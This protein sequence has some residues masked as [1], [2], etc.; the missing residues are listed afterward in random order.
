MTATNNS[1]QQQNNTNNGSNGTKKGIGAQIA[2]QVVGEPAKKTQK[3]TLNPNDLVAK[4]KA[5]QQISVTEA[6]II[7]SF[8]ESKKLLAKEYEGYIANFQNNLLEK[9]SSLTALIESEEFD[10]L[11]IERRRQIRAEKAQIMAEKPMDKDDYVESNLGAKLVRL[12]TSECS[13]KKFRVSEL[14]HK[15]AATLIAEIHNPNSAWFSKYSDE[16]KKYAEAFVQA[17]RPKKGEAL[18]EQACTFSVVMADGEC[19]D[20]DGIASIH[21]NADGTITISITF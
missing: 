15:R 20:G 1:Q 10:E 7:A 12:A 17:L 4:A 9:A 16:Y 8:N 3:P 18:G 11:P 14:T 5:E 19:H 13:R 21:R 6:V 2:K